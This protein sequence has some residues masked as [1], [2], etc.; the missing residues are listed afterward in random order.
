MDR[1]ARQLARSYL[2]Y[3]ALF[4]DSLPLPPSKKPV[5]RRRTTALKGALEPMP[6]NLETFQQEISNCR[7]CP[8]GDARSHI[9]FGDGNPHARIVFVGEA[10]GA[11]EDKQGI[12]FVGQAGQLLN[13]LLEGVGFERRDVYICNVLKC[14]PPQN[15][16]PKPDE[17][18]ACSPYL[19]SQLSLI[20]PE[21]LVCLGRHAASTL[22]G[23]DAPMKE[24]RG[25]VLPWQGFQ[26][27]VTYHPAYYLRNM[28]N[29]HIG[30]EDFQLLRR[31]Y[32]ELC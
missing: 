8:L 21:I 29:V 6:K 23:T 22:L 14:R 13:K 2:N 15:R 20:N 31:L 30:Q 1:D 18:E 24:L 12:P 19:M 32:D 28:N 5:R 11:E 7:N 16:D 27:L 25:R 9:V 10:P 26:V 17:V 3:L 4:E